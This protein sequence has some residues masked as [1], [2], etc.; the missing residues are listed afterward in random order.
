MG[1]LPA[2]SGSTRRGARLGDNPHRPT[3]PETERLRGVAERRF[4]G[5]RVVQHFDEI[6]VI[7]PGGALA[8]RGPFED[9]AGCPARVVRFGPTP[10]DFRRTAGEAFSAL[11]ALAGARRTRH[12]VGAVRADRAGNSDEGVV[13]H[14]P[15]PGRPRPR[16]WHGRRHGQTFWTCSPW[17][18]WCT[19]GP[20]MQ[21]PL[22][23]HGSGS[24]RH[25]LEGGAR[26]PK[27]RSMGL[28][29]WSQ[30]T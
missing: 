18:R 28:T 27:L 25:A 23:S 15:Q 10:R 30:R 29:A 16:R 22:T 13:Q 3:W 6:V 14:L 12:R 2:A 19:A 9:D 20:A 24:A 4:R 17:P 7:A 5:R 26:L 1:S 11:T 21:R 8:P